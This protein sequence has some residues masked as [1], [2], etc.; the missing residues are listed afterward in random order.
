MKLDLTN[1]IFEYDTATRCP[2]CLILK[3]LV[4]T[5]R[6]QCDIL[7]VSKKALQV[8]TVKSSRARWGTY[9]VHSKYATIC[10]LWPITPL[11]H[12]LLMNSK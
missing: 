3:I 5:E 6:G 12:L 2:I 4:A 1:K 8:L 11:A 10:I 7:D 9:F